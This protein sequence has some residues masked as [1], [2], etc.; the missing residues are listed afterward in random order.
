MKDN[1]A[2][3]FLTFPLPWVLLSGPMSTGQQLFWTHLLHPRLMPCFESAFYFAGHEPCPG[4]AVRE[5]ERRGGENRSLHAHAQSACL[6]AET[7]VQATPRPLRSQAPTA[8]PLRVSCDLLR[9]HV[10]ICDWTPLSQETHPLLDP[11]SS[12]S[13]YF[14]ISSSQRPWEGGQEE[15]ATPL[16]RS[17]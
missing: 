9:E 2:F 16:F 1:A 8:N 6:Y 5:Q 14:S 3:L 17:S 10:C 15:R 13:D 12:L 7:R 11:S 4:R